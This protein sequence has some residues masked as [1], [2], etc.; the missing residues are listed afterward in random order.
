MTHFNYIW[1]AGDGK[2]Y[3]KVG[4]MSMKG[5]KIN[6]TEIQWTTLLVNI[7]EVQ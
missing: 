6:P 5:Y 2:N 7:V 1:E 3:D 4:D